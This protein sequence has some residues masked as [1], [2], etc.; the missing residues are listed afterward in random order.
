VAKIKV[1]LSRSRGKR[2][3]KKKAGRLLAIDADVFAYQAALDAL[4]ERRE[5]DDQWTYWMDSR[6][7]KTNLSARIA[8]LLVE[9]DADALVLCFGS[10]SN[11]RKRVLP[12]YKANRSWR[13]PLGYEDL[14][15]WMM[16]E[17]ESLR[18]PFLEADDLVGILATGGLPKL[19]G[20][21]GEVV[22]VSEDKDLKSVPGR[23]YNPRHPELGVVEILEDD[24]DRAH[25]LQALAGD[26]ADNYKGCPGIGA[27]KAARLLDAHAPEDWWA[28]VVEAFESAG[29]SEEVAL[30]QARIARILRAGEYDFDTGDLT[31][32][33]PG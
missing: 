26:S 31:L 33:A 21:Y 12:A 1:N 14:V 28:A 4:E 5:R 23:L 13:K 24:A 17:W 29:E 8:S 9:L 20:Q 18:Q 30:T 27:V 2:E 7:A 16:A 3:G 19:T 22:H 11:W 10:T 6:E 25:L 15:N 32:W